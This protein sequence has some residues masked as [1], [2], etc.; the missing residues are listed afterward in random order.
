[1]LGFCRSWLTGAPTRSPSWWGEGD[2]EDQIIAAFK[3]ALSLRTLK[4]PW[5]VRKRNRLTA[6]GRD[7]LQK[8]GDE[9][10]LQIVVVSSIY[11]HA[12]FARTRTYPGSAL[13]LAFSVFSNLSLGPWVVWQLATVH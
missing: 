8:P 10:Q 1:L 9:H 13:P 7:G 2:P 11:L 3:N 5:P 12:V 6:A 4:A